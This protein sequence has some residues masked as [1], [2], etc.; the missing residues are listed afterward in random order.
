MDVMIGFVDDKLSL[1]GKTLMGFPI[2]GP[3]KYLEEI[4]ANDVIV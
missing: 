1:W 3:I 4:N 2:L